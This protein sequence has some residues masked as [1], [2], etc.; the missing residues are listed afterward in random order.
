MSMGHLIETFVLNDLA[1]LAI[2]V[3]LLAGTF[4]LL[5]S[6]HEV[7]VVVY[8]FDGQAVTFYF[9]VLVAKNASAR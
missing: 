3:G 8:A 4:A 5:L 1:R 2:V 6:G 9:A 7:P